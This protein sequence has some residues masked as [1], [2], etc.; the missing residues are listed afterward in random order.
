MEFNICDQRKNE[1]QVGPIGLTLPT[2]MKEQ[3]SKLIEA[4]LIFGVI[5]IGFTP[6]MAMK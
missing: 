6:L 5:I 1:S 2:E 3:S 4:G